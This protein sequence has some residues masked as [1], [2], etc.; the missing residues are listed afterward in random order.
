MKRIAILGSL[1]LTGCAS[2]YFEARVDRAGDFHS[3]AEITPTDAA[4]RLYIENAPADFALDENGVVRY[5]QSK[6]EYLGKLYVRR[7][8]DNWRWGFVSYNEPWRR[9]F[10]PPAMTLTYGTAFIFGVLGPLYV[11]GYENSNSLK[12]IEERKKHL[13]FAAIERG[14]WI[15]AT[16]I[17]YAT[18]T[19]VEYP[20]GSGKPVQVANG[21]AVTSIASQSQFPYMGMVAHAFKRK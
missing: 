3:H 17:I 15:G 7:N 21:G 10:C 14:M 6:Y 4:P 5:D 20:E 12:R 19:G 1:L 9:Y 18:Y 8:F 13:A 2:T 11:C 16:H